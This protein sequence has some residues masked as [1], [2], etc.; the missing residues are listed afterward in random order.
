MDEGGITGEGRS[1]S[2]KS[3]EGELKPEQAKLT[4]RV[5]SIKVT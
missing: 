4:A 3:G 5:L 2:L 1:A